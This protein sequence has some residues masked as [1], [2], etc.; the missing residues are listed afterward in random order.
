MKKLLLSIFLGTQLCGGVSE[1]WKCIIT[2]QLFANQR[3]LTTNEEKYTAFVLPYI[4]QIEQL[5]VTDLLI[6]GSRR[7]SFYQ[8][9]YLLIHMI[10]A[11]FNM[12]FPG[13]K[14]QSLFRGLQE[15]LVA[16]IAKEAK[17]AGSSI[18]AEEQVHTIVAIIREANKAYYKKLVP[19]HKK[20]VIKIAS[21]F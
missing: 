1:E 16:L 6:R 10:I 3:A 15:H 7:S 19:L 2:Q 14:A 11:D 5:P 17:D 12:S 21:L 8:Y 20:I 13:V 4:E 18:N 9:C